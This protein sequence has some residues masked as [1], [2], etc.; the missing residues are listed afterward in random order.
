MR[1]NVSLPFAVLHPNIGSPDPCGPPPEPATFAFIL[2]YSVGGSVGY[3][4]LDG[5]VP[6]SGN[7]QLTCTGGRWQRERL[8][9]RSESH[10]VLGLHD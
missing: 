10:V 9:C 2:S 3:S 7:E 8:H 6:I 5:Y 1:F 4:C